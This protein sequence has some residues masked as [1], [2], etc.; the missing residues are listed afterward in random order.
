MMNH[1]TVL[2]DALSSVDQQVIDKNTEERCRRSKRSPGGIRKEGGNGGRKGGWIKWVAI[3]AC[4]CLVLPLGVFLF[5]QG[6]KQIPVYQGMTISSAATDTAGRTPI[7]SAASVAPAEPYRLTGLSLASQ[8]P[9]L[10]PLADQRYGTLPEDGSGTEP[11]TAPPH[12]WESGDETWHPA[13]SWE[14]RPEQ[15]GRQ[16]DQILDELLRRAEEDRETSTGSLTVEGSDRSIY[17]AQA[18]QDIYITVHISNPDNYEILSFTL[19]GKTYASYMFEP[20]SD[21]EHLILK[22]NVGDAEGI[23]EYTIDAIKYVDGTAIKDVLMEGDK[24][25]RAGVYSDKQPTAELQNQVVGINT[26]SFD[27]TTTDPL[28]LISQSGGQLLAVLTNGTQLLGQQELTVGETVTV[29]FDGLP[30]GGSYTCSIVAIYDALDGSGVGRYV[31]AETSGST[32]TIVGFDG[33]TTT[34]DGLSFELV[35]NPAHTDHTVEALALYDG[36]ELLQTLDTSATAVAGLLSDH[37]YRLVATYRNGDLAE[38]AELTFKTEAKTLPTLSLTAG[39][40]TQSSLSF[41][42]DLVDPD[43]VA[44][45]TSIELLHGEDEPIRAESLDQRSFEGLLSDNDYTVRVTATYDLNDGTGEHTL[46]ETVSCRT[47]AKAMPSITL[48]DIVVDK[49]I[50]GRYDRSDPDGVLLQDT[51]ELYQGDRRV[52][53]GAPTE[54]GSFLF[55]GL[56]PYTPYTLR[57]TYTYDLG[58]GNGEQTESHDQAYTTSPYLGITT[59]TVQNTEAVVEGDTIYLQIGMQNLSNAT[60][61]KV[62]VNGRVYTANSLKTATIVQ[63][64]NEGQFE[65]GDTTLTVEKLYVQIGDQQWVAAPETSCQANVYINGKLTV[66]YVEWVDQD[67]KTMDWCHATDKAYFLIHLYNPTGYP[68]ERVQI[69][70]QSFEP[71]A[72]D[73]NTIYVSQEA[74]GIDTYYGLC[75]VALQ[76]LTYRSSSGSVSYDCSFA[77]NY[78][79]LSPDA[80][81]IHYISQPSDLLDMD[82]GYYYELTQDIDLSGI[83]WNRNSDFKGVFNGNGHSIRNMSCL[84]VSDADTVGLFSRAKGVIYDLHME[85][86]QVSVAADMSSREY[87]VGTIACSM[88]GTLRGCSVDASSSVNVQAG[89]DGYMGGLVG[90]GDYIL[91]CTNRA[92]VSVVTRSTGTVGYIGGIAGM[93]GCVSNC[94]NNGDISVSESGNP[95]SLACGIAND[96][97]F[98]IRN[99]LNTGT[100]T[101]GYAA[102]ILRLGG[103]PLISN[104]LSVGAMDA[105]QIYSIAHYNAESHNNDNAIFDNNYSLISEGLDLK[106]GVVSAVTLEQLSDPSFYTDVLGWDASIWCFDD[107]DPANGKYPTLR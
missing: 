40:V 62:Q 67:L 30:T 64:P 15:V 4:I 45:L 16:L 42:L 18:N 52:A 10:L 60:I 85:N 9:A 19:N 101:G 90:H 97:V 65:G 88:S 92:A 5:R 31:L 81:E 63:I 69:E 78:Y 39:D 21:M 27:V 68:I 22:Y 23:V 29:A 13:P 33:V 80:D 100:I 7:S 57:T 6:G 107:L 84:Y 17:Y 8:T 56:D 55:D 75:D 14:G 36:E 2:L 106:Q 20:G 70:D 76:S 3:A 91:E 58:D 83:V 86:C 11:E 59:C 103:I 44:S 28:A 37:T 49:T 61:T 94:V 95:S 104:C 89:H 77:A 105:E 46:T 1:D 50:A 41:V 71:V 96:C 87:Y 47:V 102:G 38:T 54:D 99:C 98:G 35:W 53:V 34:K 24:T 82:D 48:L 12:G 72:V 51:L 79:R 66:E 93:A 25:V 73:A 32:Q 43:G 74:R 26:L